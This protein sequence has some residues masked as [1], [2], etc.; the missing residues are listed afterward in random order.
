MSGRILRS[1]SVI[2]EGKTNKQIAAS[3]FLSEHTVK[4]YVSSILQKLGFSRR[5]EV[6]AFVTRH[7]PVFA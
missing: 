3:L 5:A 6:A 1:C 2:V 4:D 7:Q